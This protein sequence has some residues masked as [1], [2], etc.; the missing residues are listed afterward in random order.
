MMLLFM[1]IAYA[2]VTNTQVENPGVLIGSWNGSSGTPVGKY[3][4]LTAKHVGGPI[5]DPGCTAALPKGAVFKIGGKHYCI[6]K[7]DD[8]PT[9]DIS[10]LTINKTHNPDGFNSFV[11]VASSQNKVGDK[12]ITGG[13]GYGAGQPTPKGYP[14]HGMY[15]YER[16]GEN[17]IN[18]VS[19]AYITTKFD[20]AP[21]ESS[22]ALYDSGSTLLT[23]DDCGNYV[24][25]GVYVSTS[26][27]TG[28]SAFGDRSYAVNLATHYAWIKSKVPDLESETYPQGDYTKDGFVDIQDFNYVASNFG[29]TT[30]VKDFNIV[31]SFFG[32]KECK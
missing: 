3:Y 24:A 4:V 15:G 26:S 8:H 31:S 7:R 28:F 25:I 27:S 14:W 21:N 32:K 5:N 6:E 9:A 23:K 20:N 22:A 29:K 1:G 12:T 30:N 13:F 19:S 17:T 2:V 10:V 16:W 11:G 18:A